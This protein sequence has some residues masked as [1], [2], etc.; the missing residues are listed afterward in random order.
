MYHYPENHLFTKDKLI[1]YYEEKLEETRKE[2]S[3]LKEMDW[4]WGELNCRI[5]MCRMIIN[6]LTRLK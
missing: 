4:Y 6:H 1:K 3:E 2:L 5:D